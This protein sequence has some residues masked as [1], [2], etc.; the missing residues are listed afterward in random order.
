MKSGSILAGLI[1]LVLIPQLVSSQKEDNTWF[2][3]NSG[4]IRFNGGKAKA[5][6]GGEVYTEEGSAVISDKNG[7]LI[8]YTD[9][10]TQNFEFRVYY[11]GRGD[12]S[13]YEFEVDRLE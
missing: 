12:L 5:I 1:F 11:S 4:G 2:F 6:S 13:F 9:G 10:S 7:K 8:F 3:G